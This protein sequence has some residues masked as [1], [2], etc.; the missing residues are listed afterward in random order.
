MYNIQYC[1]I[2]HFKSLVFHDAV[3]HKT[4]TLAHKKTLDIQHRQI[5]TPPSYSAKK[6]IS[7]LRVM[8]K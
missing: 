5:L 4:M 8:A 1:V 3:V 7:R 2:K 6:H